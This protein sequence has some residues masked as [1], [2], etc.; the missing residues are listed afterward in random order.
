ME[1]TPCIFQD[2]SDLSPRGVA[3]TFQARAFL[4]FR[5]T[6]E[7]NNL[8]ISVA[9][10]LRPAPA[11]LCASCTLMRRAVC[12]SCWRPT[13]ASCAQCALTEESDEQPLHR[14]I[15]LHKKR[16]CPETFGEN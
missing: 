12:E 16:L 14:E 10:G 1:P 7:T 9:V 6:F 2:A 3:C 15:R 4:V 13:R 11:S 8:S 5:H